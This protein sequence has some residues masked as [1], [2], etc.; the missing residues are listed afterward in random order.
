VTAALANRHAAG[1]QWREA[2]AAFDA[3][4]GMPPHRPEA[5][6]RTHG[7]LRLAAALLHENR[8]GDA[9]EL[10]RGGARRRTE[11]GVRSADDKVGPGFTYS[12]ADGIV[13][14]TD[15]LSGFP[16]RRAGVRPGDILVKVDD[17][18]LTS[19]SIPKLS[20]LLAGQAGTNVRLTVRRA[21]SEQP[22]VI[23]V[24]RQQFIHDE[25]TGELLHPLRMA[26][27]ERLAREPRNPTLLEL[28]AE[29]AGQW[30][31]PKAQVAD[32]TAAI[33][34]LSQQRPAARS[35]DLRRLYLRRGDAYLALKNGASAAEDYARA[36]GGDATD[37]AL[38]NQALAESET[39]LGKAV[40]TIVPT[41]E[42]EG[43]KWR[44]TTQKPAEGWNQNQFD[45]S[46][47][48]DGL[49]P[50]GTADRQPRTQWW[51][52]EIWIRHTFEGS[53]LGDWKTLLLRLNVD[54][55]V[56]VFLNGQHLADRLAW[57][58]AAYVFQPIG[59]V[60]PDLFKPGKNTLALHCRN[61]GG[62]GYIDVGLYAT[63]KKADQVPRFID[64]N[65]VANPW[66]KLALAYRLDENPQAVDRLVERRPQAAGSLG[67][68][69][70]A[71][72][73]WRRA[74]SIYSKRI[75]E[76]TTDADLLSKRARAHEALR[77][78]E[79]AAAD[80]SRAAA[81]NL[82]G[83]RLLASFARRLA[84]AG[85]KPLAGPP[86]VRC[87]QILEAAL[88]QDPGNGPVASE[89]ARLLFE[90]S[91]AEWAILKPLSMKSQ[92]GATMTLLEDGS[93]LVSGVNPDKDVYE[94]E[95]RVDEA[96]L[97][98]IRLE[99]LTHPSLPRAGH[100]RAANGNV[101]MTEFEAEVSKAGDPK[102]WS[103]IKF[104]RAWADHAQPGSDI[105]NT[106]DGNSGTGW[107]TEGF[108]YQEDRKAIFV[109][110]SPFGSEGGSRLRIRLRHESGNT[111]HQFGRFRLAVTRSRDPMPAPTISDWRIGLATAYA[112][113]GE[114]DQAAEWFG[115]SLGE[116]G[117]SRAN[118][119]D[120]VR[121]LD[122]GDILARLQKLRPDDVSLQVAVAR[123]HAR[124][125]GAELERKRPA[126]ALAEL[127]QAQQ[128]FGAI[129][130]SH[131]GPHW[132]VLKPIEMKS[133]GGSTLTR[134]ADDSML[135]SG[136]NP[137]QD[138]YTVVA[139]A[140][141]DRIS[142][143][144]L[145]ALPDPSLPRGTSGRAPE[146]GNFALTEWKVAAQPRA[147][148]GAPR[149]IRWRDAASDVR[150]EPDEHYEKRR[151]HIGMAIDGD[152]ETY[153]ETWPKS[154]SPHWAVF[155]PAEPIGRATDGTLRFILEFQSRYIHHNLG[156]FRLS[157]T[158]DPDALE[159]ES[160]HQDLATRELADLD[161]A[162]GRAQVQQEQVNEAAASLAQAL[163]RVAAGED[164]NRL[165]DR[166]GVVDDV[167][168][169]TGK[170]RPH[171]RDLQ[172]A[173]ARRHTERGKELLKQQRRTDALG[174]L[175]Q[176]RD[177]FARLIADSARSL[178]DPSAG[179]LRDLAVSLGQALAQANRTGEAVSAFDRAI[180]L[181][182]DREAV[183]KVV[184]ELSA[185]SGML[186][187][188]AE[189][190]AADA[191][192]Q[193]VL[194]RYHAGRGD[195]P[196]AREPLARSRAAYEKQLGSV[197]RN[198]QLAKVLADLLLEVGPA[199]WTV[200]QPT[201]MKSKGGA[202]LSKLPD[203]S[204][205]AGGRNSLGD[206][207][208][209]V[210]P[211]NVPRVA[212]IRLE[213]LTHDTLPN[214]GPGRD[215]Q[216]DRGNFAMVHFTI[217]ARDPGS[218]PRPV[219]V[220]RVAADHSLFE[221]TAN[222]WNI[223]GG[224]ESRPH[225][226][227]YLVTR[228]V[229]LSRLARLEFQMAFS[230]NAD[231]PLQNLG[232]FRLS[233][234]EDAGAFA[235][236]ESRLAAMKVTDPW[237]R[238]GAAYAAV[239]DEARSLET[240]SQAL[241][242]APDD[243]AKVEVA[244]LAAPFEEVLAGLINRM[245]KASF[246]RHGQAKYLV[247]RRI[248]EGRSEES[249]HLASQALE[250]FPSDLDLLSWRAEAEMKLRRWSAAIQDYGLLIERET[251]DGK[252]RAA[253]LAKAEAHL[254][255]GQWTDAADAYAA[256]M[257]LSATWDHLRDN[258]GA[259][260]LAG[261]TATARSAAARLLQ[262][263]PEKPTDAYWAN[264]L[265]SDF[266]AIPGMITA[267][268]QGRLLGAAQ[269]AGGD[270]S[271]P[272]SAAINYRMG[273]LKEAEPL[274][275]TS[276][277]RPEFLS[278][279]AMLLY[280]RGEMPRAR[281]FLRQ[282]DAWFQQQRDHEPDSAIP[283]SQSWQE[284][285]VRLAAWREAAR[286][287]AG[288]RLT[289]LDALLK[290]G[291]ENA[292]ALLERAKLLTTVGLYEDALADLNRMGK[293]K[294]DSG[295]YWG[296][297]GRVLA[298]LNRTDEALADLNKA[299]KFKSTDAVVYA[300][301]GGILRK[302]G[303]AER[304]RADL[305]KSLNLEPSEPA[306]D[307]LAD[308]LR[309]TLSPQ[310]R[311]RLA[312]IKDSKGWARL[313]AVYRLLDQD[314]KL[315]RL[316]QTHPA[317]AES[318]AEG[319]FGAHE[320]KRA[321]TFYDKIIQGDTKDA[322]LFAR[323]AESYGKLNQWPQADADWKRALALGP[324]GDEVM[325]QRWLAALAEAKRWA[326]IAREFSAQ[327]DKLPE[328]LASYE[329]RGKLIGA[330]IRRHAPVFEA[331]LA[332]RPKDSLLRVSQARDFVL[333]SDWKHAAKAYEEIIDQVPLSESW[334]EC[335]AALL[336]ARKPENHREVLKRLLDRA[337]DTKDPYLAF[338]IA[339]AAVLSAHEIVPP[340]KVA[341][342]GNAATKFPEATS[343]HW[344]VAGLAEWRAGHT[345]KALAWLDKSAATDWHPELNHIARCLVYA[346]RKETDKARNELRQ[347]REWLA[348]TEAGRND[349]YYDVQDTDWLE[350][351]VLIREAEE[352][353]K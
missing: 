182:A 237:P 342:W 333:R 268:N 30:S 344:H 213:A 338:A 214:Q 336:L 38:A 101:V 29:L 20:E 267:E 302:L 184:Q 297:R 121:L 207:Y 53:P 335:C 23:V 44:F 73:D 241:A 200:L 273:R 9:V 183:S 269:A 242:L 139:Q 240:F 176:A 51:S 65:A 33:A 17:V 212:A 134:L 153:W 112:R 279:A 215:E 72:R 42:A 178:P 114:E 314:A 171:D 305:E 167:L 303:Q 246:L 128:Q 197:P 304:A 25:E 16:G 226:A 148:L 318:I 322:R 217:Q 221:L 179:G 306:A 64:A 293:Q 165:I 277:G 41:S 280:D 58:E 71:D 310:Q 141:L 332:L 231:W 251:D 227:I 35:A 161:V 12:T 154:A 264:I 36:V 100:S 315:D 10:M 124:R 94:V 351:K 321:I 135:A 14:V 28:R 133:Q 278:L 289:E 15:W 281:E 258:L 84:E 54:D 170:F 69:F 236:E 228:P 202:T 106:I 327:L 308:L 265:A 96:G 353:L 317:T 185:L 168:A 77:N 102:Q 347:V 190:R 295:E 37:D 309:E 352:R 189:A 8:P 341:D 163:N 238:L 254:R 79:A 5:W 198:I 87:R 276:A 307:L 130:A 4:K 40:N 274:L 127:A 296:L 155:V 115:K 145:E 275:T 80:W 21:G 192:F 149:F 208:S 111:S 126:Q 113:N 284:W 52:P 224:G 140:D 188:L 235:R 223:G 110:Q 329:P 78:W 85:Q 43:V 122:S 3:L 75:S 206:A 56:E 68:L 169:A 300:A 259:E 70:A 244:R 146:N 138:V 67:D 294:S 159:G 120:M 253:E 143:F 299:I 323:R 142:A 131:P 199:G 13:R 157:V 350:L 233:V 193:D 57:T 49:A 174:Q 270:R 286:K 7:L 177:Q 319:Y 209:I 83:A 105:R 22:E 326:E 283:A 292:G 82:E 343:W 272:L 324:A 144:R 55:T 255:L 245:P 34:A 31:D 349:E 348:R 95:I 118:T 50:F 1:K 325:R 201:E 339:R 47:W 132:T 340:S 266:I 18:E 262:S 173:R 248:A 129:L 288:P 234:S 247:S 181:A 46:S 119:S 311:P 160:L 334:Y 205:L 191:R 330:V 210:A 98:G 116:A 211:A 290:K 156:R 137:D 26:V 232:R 316:V 45:D 195:W 194:A 99:G 27:N 243:R 239:G 313:G 81:G 60:P 158:G 59:T 346:S 61:P 249:L 257:L 6:F 90:M 263:L 76:K 125:G 91:G 123:S 225:T 86:R 74:I 88:R 108:V 93:I 301:R 219:E 136:P 97:T 320:W 229:T 282:A 291:P 32:Y 298:G 172:L 150:L 204:I 203:D 92:G 252:R 220:S 103:P 230:A 285:A 104:A 187:K 222:S 256:E 152:P 109:S 63:N 117:P 196:R 147:S 164:R 180:E 271:A 312:A 89:L 66:K 218:P 331:L 62:A 250:T 261:N 19:A 162:I 345:D 186:E 2:V 151:M 24:T 337:G 175:E 11:D 216:R 107:T 260:L 287:L 328:G 166:F 48:P 39:I